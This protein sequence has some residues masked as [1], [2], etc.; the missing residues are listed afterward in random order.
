MFWW[1]SNLLRS[2]AAVKKELSV[3]ENVEFAKLPS[4]A[5][6]GVPETRCPVEVRVLSVCNVPFEDGNLSF[7]VILGAQKGKSTVQEVR[8]GVAQWDGERVGLIWREHEVL[9][10]VVC[11]HRK[12]QERCLSTRRRGIQKIFFGEC[13]FN[14]AGVHRESLERRQKFTASV[15][16]YSGVE[17]LTSSVSV[18]I[19]AT[20]PAIDKNIGADV[21]V[22]PVVAQVCVNHTLGFF[23]HLR[24][25]PFETYAV[26]LQGVAA[27]FEEYRCNGLDGAHPGL[28][29]DTVAGKACRESAAAQHKILYR[30]S[31]KLKFRFLPAAR[32]VCLRSG[33]DFVHLLHKGKK[34]GKARVFTYSLVDDGLFFSETGCALLK[35]VNSKHI[36]HAHGSTTVRCAGTM[37]ICRT[38]DREYVLV[39]DND[40]GTYKPDKVGLE[41]ME[42]TLK[43]NFPRL[44]IQHLDVRDEE[45]PSEMSNWEGPKEVKGTKGAVYAG[46]WK[47]TPPRRMSVWRSSVRAVTQLSRKSTFPPHLPLSPRSPQLNSRNNEVLTETS[48]CNKC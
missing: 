41:L 36:V 22:Q 35:D 14:L 16:L 38:P 3:S 40:S 43:Y 17:A 7:R 26:L 27:M 8:D 1:A 29:R 5:S 48:A 2:D 23:Q 46:Q 34:R 6:R 4:A 47:W 19:L 20:W 15:K 9:R 13:I 39:F 30:C 21:L 44:R 25:V 11:R 10:V 45:L 37:R 33:R 42:R 24:S 32:S 31:R 18:E 12:K 28:F